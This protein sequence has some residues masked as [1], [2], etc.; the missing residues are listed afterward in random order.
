MVKQTLHKPPTFL[1][2]ISA[3]F[4][5]VAYLVVSFPDAPGRSAASYAATIAIATPAVV[6]LFRY[7]GVARGAVALL[8]LSV[9]GYAIEG[10][11]VA[12]GLPYGTFFYSEALG[13]KLFGLAPYIL[14]VSYVPLV[15]GAV[16]ATGSPNAG[17][18]G[19]LTWALKS[20]LFLTLIDGVLDPGAASLGFWVWPEGGPYYGV[21]VSNYLGWL[22]S[23]A[24]GS[25]LLLLFGRWNGTPL[26][27]LLDSVI[28]AASFWTGVAVFSWLPIP[29]LLGVALFVYLL[30]RR[31]QLSRATG[32]TGGY[33]LRAG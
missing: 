5:G 17:S 14:P 9:F 20:A 15:I 29:A 7:M 18:R 4:F 31:F 8:I 10:L 16:A 32:R 33:K 30:R 3:I 24:L 22:I 13:P 2:L 25:F 23:G 27:G 21:P 19:I 28:V 1:I 11:G 12:T 26:P 6:A